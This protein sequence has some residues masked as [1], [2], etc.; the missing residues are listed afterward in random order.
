[1]EEKHSGST[2]I[3]PTV[4]NTIAR[5][6]CLATPGVTAMAPVFSGAARGSHGET[7]GVKIVVK[8]SIIYV[9]VYVVINGAENVRVVAEA[10]Q[11]RV[12]RAISEMVGME[13]A[14]VNVHVTDIELEA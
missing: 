13:V 6:T 14:S 5:L 8:D 12:T 9:D 3:A 10:V 1:M 2:T 4:L 7:E 11:Q